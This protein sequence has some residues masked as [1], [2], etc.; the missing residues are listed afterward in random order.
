MPKFITKFRRDRW[1]DQVLTTGRKLRHA[2]AAR[3][4]VN[5]RTW[6]EDAAYL[7]AVIDRLTRKRDRLLNKLKETA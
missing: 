7:D 1:V 5:A 6:P 4:G 3:R 2:E